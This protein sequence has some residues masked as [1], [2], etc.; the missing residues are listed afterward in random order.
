MFWP[1]YFY[2]QVFLSFLPTG[3]LSPSQKLVTRL[4][5]VPSEYP[6]CFLSYQFQ[7]LVSSTSYSYKRAFLI[8]QFPKINL[9]S[10]FKKLSP[11]MF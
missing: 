3:D 9:E 4:Y 11:W 1:L 2:F 6:I 5:F 10:K 8:C 7:L